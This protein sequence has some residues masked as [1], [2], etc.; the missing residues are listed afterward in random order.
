MIQ[1][2]YS[3]K[4]LKVNYFL[5]PFPARNNAE[6]LRMLE[7]AAN[8]KQ[9]QIGKF[10][11]DYALYRLG[12]YDDSTGRT[13]AIDPTYVAGASDLVSPQNSQEN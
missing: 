8:D 9:G 2:M 6:A 4:D 3:I 13:V 5:K 7:A 1:P 10:A 12:D 11:P